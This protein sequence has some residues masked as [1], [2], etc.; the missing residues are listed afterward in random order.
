VLD[1]PL[2]LAV[3]R[4]LNVVFCNG[5]LEPRIVIKQEGEMVTIVKTT[6]SQDPENPVN[7]RIYGADPAKGT[8][9]NK[10]G[11]D[12]MSREGK[13]TAA[14]EGRMPGATVFN[15]G[16]SKAGTAVCM[17]SDDE[18]E[19][20]PRN[21]VCRAAGEIFA[22][23]HY[24]KWNKPQI[25]SMHNGK[26][27]EASSAFLRVYE[28]PMSTGRRVYISDERSFRSREP[29]AVFEP[30]DTEIAGEG[31][32][33]AAVEGPLMEIRTTA[34]FKDRHGISDRELEM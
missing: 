33:Q 3:A 13:A 34:S 21:Q 8:P 9:W 18:L 6:N 1:H 25:G 31:N 14:A 32:D 24:S 27:G 10:N 26:R 5:E 7:H 11:G 16:G 4:R 15:S 12:E 19:I 20:L 17:V 30:H 23:R 22:Q 2:Q 29:K 28:H